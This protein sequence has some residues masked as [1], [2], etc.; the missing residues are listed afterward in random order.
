MH[1]AVGSNPFY[2]ADA[3]KGTKFFGSPPGTTLCEV[4]VPVKQI[5]KVVHHDG[6]LGGSIPYP[7]DV[8]DQREQVIAATGVVATWKRAH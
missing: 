2:P 6:Y 1:G 3:A 5:L 8:T 4:E 7:P